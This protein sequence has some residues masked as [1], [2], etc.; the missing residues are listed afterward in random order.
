MGSRGCQT[1]YATSRLAIMILYNNHGQYVNN[2]RN[3]FRGMPFF[4]E[5]FLRSAIN[6]T[7]ILDKT[8][9]PRCMNVNCPESR[10]HTIS[11]TANN[12]AKCM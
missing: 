6:V 2:V 5:I 3:I 1:R 9:A 11:K 8:P 4:S 7:K 12:A 10:T